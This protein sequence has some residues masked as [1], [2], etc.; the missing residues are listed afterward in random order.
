MSE[1]VRRVKVIIEV[2]GN[3]FFTNFHQQTWYIF[4]S[5][6]VLTKEAFQ[7]FIVL[8]IKYWLYPDVHCLSPPGDI[9]PTIWKRSHTDLLHSTSQPISHFPPSHPSWFQAYTALSVIF[10]RVGN[11]KA[12]GKMAWMTSEPGPRWECWEVKIRTD[13]QFLH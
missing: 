3:I 5:K 12:Q 1:Y 9:I 11:A 13:C 4:Y 8:V 2:H 10:W 7:F 6:C